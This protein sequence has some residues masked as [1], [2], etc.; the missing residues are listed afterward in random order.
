[1]SLLIKAATLRADVQWLQRE[2][3]L[4]AILERVP[5]ST[6]LLLRDPPLASTWVDSQ[7]GEAVLRALESVDGK[8]AVLR[9]SREK[10][11]DGLLPPLRPMIAGVLRL[12]GTSPATLYRRMN[13]LV[14]TSVRGMEFIYQPVSTRAGVMQVRY[15]VERE[16]PTCMFISCMAALEIALELCGVQG[17]V[18][19]PERISPASARFRI[20][21]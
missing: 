4:A 13:D 16:V 3:R 8:F 20:V 19:E 7:H 11:R 21:W 15:D 18:S 9:M 1:M 5:P 2:N 14:K 17:T 6:A 12:F 10:L